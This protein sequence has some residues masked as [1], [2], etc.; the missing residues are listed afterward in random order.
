MH[1]NSP[2]TKEEYIRYIQDIAESRDISMK[3]VKHIMQTEPD[4]ALWEHHLLEVQ[5][6]PD[7][8]YLKNKYMYCHLEVTAKP[9]GNPMIA[10]KQAILG[11][12]AG[13]VHEFTPNIEPLPDLFG[14]EKYYTDDTVLSIA[15]MKAIQENASAPNFAKWY[16]KMFRKYP[17]AGYGS[18]FRGW[19]M[20]RKRF[21]KKLKQGQSHGNGCLMRIGY[22]PFIYPYYTAVDKAIESCLTSHCN[23]SSVK[24]VIL[25]VTCCYMAMYGMQK[26]HI[27]K[28]IQ[29]AYIN[30]KS[31][32]VFGDTLDESRQLNAHH[33]QNISIKAAYALCESIDILTDP[34]INSFIDYLYKAIETGGDVD[35][36]CAIGGPLC[37]AMWKTEDFLTNNILE[38]FNVPL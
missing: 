18:G 16:R 4:V 25:Y 31:G 6:N 10:V 9:I 14:D 15:T 36:I 32:Y 30:N 38:K 11:D 24:A 28:Y 19:A 33:P 12:I 26:E 5:T 17:H 13:S 3:Q 23:I 7:I 20:Q 27:R 35:T 37:Y 1:N 34:N 8:D 22:I 29:Q 21:F 2:E